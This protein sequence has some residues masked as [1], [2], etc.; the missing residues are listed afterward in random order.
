MIYFNQIR[1]K[2]NLL[3]KTRFPGSKGP[4]TH[5]IFHAKQAFPV[6]S[7]I[8]CCA[9]PNSHAADNRKIDGKRLLRR[10]AISMQFDSDLPRNAGPAF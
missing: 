9:R 6:D 5:A 1:F 2:A 10:L 3:E 4:F 8:F 7:S